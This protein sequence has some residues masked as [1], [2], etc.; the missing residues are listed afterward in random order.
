M[1][2]R[3]AERF[4]VAEG[5]E[6]RLTPEGP[7]A[8]HIVSRGYL[9][10]RVRTEDRYRLRAAFPGTAV[11]LG[12]ST[13][14][15]VE[16][17]EQG[18]A[19]V[20]RLARWPE[21]EVQR[22]RVE[23]GPRLVRAAQAERERTRTRERLRPLRWFLYPV[24]GLLPEEQQDRACDRL[25]LYAVTATLVS[26]LVESLG[27]LVVLWLASRASD[28]GRRVILLLSTPLLLA[29]VLP[30]LGRA[31]SAVAFRETAGSW[32]VI[33]GYEIARALGRAVERHDATL[34][35]LTRAAF[36]ERLALPDRI[37]READGSLLYA[38][39]LP[40]LTWQGGRRLEAAGHHWLPALLPPT[41]HRGRLLHQYRV[42]RLGDPVSPGEAEPPGPPATA[43]SEEVLNG[44]QREWDDLRVGFDW[45]VSLLATT[46]QKRACDL[47]GGPPAI[48][49]WT[50]ITAA[51]SIVL[52][53]YLLSFLPRGPAA[54]PLAPFVGVFG[55]FLVA[56]GIQRWYRS[57]QGEYAPSLL[58]LV[59]PRDSL[60]PERLAFHAHRD[61]EREALRSWLG[62]GGSR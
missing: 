27:F 33:L 2:P 19:V 39:T 45:L 5:E 46:L 49:R 24:V 54:D 50:V 57:S 23:Y 7:T 14:E 59:L 53:L 12:E 40:H 22:D 32:P 28:E 37:E 10:L 36:W 15:V 4:R 29:F 9:P 21:G 47:R 41:L 38:S 52:G 58:R 34:V 44:I 62:G 6:A 1:P 11:V 31:F 20:Y 26:G 61:A 55:L 17:V 25:G 13:F 42:A 8:A 43:Y 3:G 51:T 56:E 18:E 60:R 30:G 16:E 48:R 35:P